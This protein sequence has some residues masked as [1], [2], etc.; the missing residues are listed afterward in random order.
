MSESSIQGAIRGAT[1]SVLC[2]VLD[3]CDGEI[4][5]PKGLS[6]KFGA[7]VDILVDWL[8]IVAEKARFSHV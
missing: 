1:F 3:Y 2:Y 4:A 6:S 8:T 7:A 5:R